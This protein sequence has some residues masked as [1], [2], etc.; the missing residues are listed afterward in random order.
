MRSGR[1]RQNKRTAGR[2]SRCFDAFAV[3]AFAFAAGTWR[4][5]LTAPLPPIMQALLLVSSWRCS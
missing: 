3:C 4:W 5:L 1:E 2:P